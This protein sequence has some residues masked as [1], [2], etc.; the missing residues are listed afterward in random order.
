VIV[1]DGKPKAVLMDYKEFE[2]LVTPRIVDSLVGKMSEIEGV[3]KEVRKAQLQDL[4]EEIIQPDM[5]VIS[6]DVVADLDE[7]ITIEPLDLH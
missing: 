4:R 1:E 2:E 7:G 3:N 6:E 5:D